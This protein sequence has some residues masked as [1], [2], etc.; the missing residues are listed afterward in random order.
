VDNSQFL[1]G[2]APHGFVVDGSS[3]AELNGIYG[4]KLVAGLPELPPLLAPHVSLGL[5]RHTD[6]NGWL[7]ANLD[8][9]HEA[10]P[11]SDSAAVRAAGG[12][13]PRGPSSE[14]VFIDPATD[15]RFRYVPGTDLVPGHGTAWSHCSRQWHSGGGVAS[16]G[17]ETVGDVAELPM[18][19][20]PI[21]GDGNG[22]TS[23]YFE[24]ILVQY[25]RQKA[26]EAAANERARSRAEDDE[27][28]RGEGEQCPVDAAALWELGRAM[29]DAGRPSA[30]LRAFESLYATER[31]WPELLRWL[32]A[33][34]AAVARVAAHASPAGRPQDEH[35]EGCETMTVGPHHAVYPDH[36][37]RVTLADPKLRCPA[38]VDRTNWL[39]AVDTLKE[40]AT[41]YVF[42][43]TQKFGGAVTVRRGEEMGVPITHGWEIDLRFL[44]CPGRSALADGDG[45][46]PPEPPGQQPPGRKI[47]EGQ[48]DVRGDEEAQASAEVD[49]YVVLGLRRDGSLEELKKA[50]RQASI[51]LHP[52]KPGGSDDAFARA[53]VAHDCLVDEEC[54][55]SFD[56]GGDLNRPNGEQSFAEAVEH[57]YFP[58]TTPFYPFGDPATFA[59][60]RKGRPGSNDVPPPH[61]PP[62][63]AQPPGGSKGSPRTN[64]AA[65]TCCSGGSCPDYACC[66]ADG[67]TPC[68]GNSCADGACK[69]RTCNATPPPPL[70]P[71]GQMG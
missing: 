62:P 51:T 67:V 16:G 42:D 28:E 18:L 4:P 71:R 7:L 65:R 60:R 48:Q 56:Q 36:Q 15:H 69:D 25:R 1:I 23:H 70:L 47:A 63:P 34:S 3:I 17:L 43:V 6:G 10:P 57:R 66:K 22:Q 53:A 58:Q 52:D 41:H 9:V 24:Q 26:A 49:H 54:R 37:K 33:A 50:Y 32:V 38:R 11:A 39:V 13:E 2:E 21:P 29:L 31:D 8:V 61:R 68:G 20:A 30:A 12:A 27:E 14:W 40:M 44:C 55:A 59:E 64:C 45:S 35:A 19:L 5:Y 46:A